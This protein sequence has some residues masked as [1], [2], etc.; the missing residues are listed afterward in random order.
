MNKLMNKLMN[1]SSQDHQK[2]TL[3]EQ[4][5]QCIHADVLYIYLI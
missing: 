2:L 3:L 5:F 4:I 1:N